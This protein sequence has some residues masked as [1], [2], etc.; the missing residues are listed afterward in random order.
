M[1][2]FN[3]AVGDEFPLNEGGPEGRHHG[4]HG[5][6]GRCGHRHE[7]HGHRHHPLH[8]VGHLARLAIVAGLI[9]LLVAG[10]I[11][12]IAATSMIGLGVAAILLL[13]FVRMR[14]FR[15]MRGDSQ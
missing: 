8:F 4:R 1:T 14:R 9:A 6:H 3:V 2:K 11:P 12:A 15:R 7:H 10:K 5:R 13:G